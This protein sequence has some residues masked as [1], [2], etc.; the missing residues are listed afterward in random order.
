MILDGSQNQTQCG[1]HTSMCKITMSDTL[2]GYVKFAH[3]E[4]ELSGHCINI[5]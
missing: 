3:T 1:L 4:E 5:F 2:L